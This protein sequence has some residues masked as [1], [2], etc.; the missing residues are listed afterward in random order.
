MSDPPPGTGDDDT[1]PIDELAVARSLRRL[2]A[3]IVA[4]PELVASPGE[5]A[6][7]NLERWRAMLADLPDEPQDGETD[8]ASPE[9]R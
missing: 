3:L 2:D 1:A 7:D 4:Y 8:D 9:E 5:L 6:P